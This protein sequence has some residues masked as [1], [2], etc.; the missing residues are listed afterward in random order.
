MRLSQLFFLLVD[1]LLGVNTP[2]CL[3]HSVPKLFSSI[4]PDKLR[5]PN[6][7]FRGALC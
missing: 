5:T 4:G 3:P 1:H 7:T 2:A 6:K